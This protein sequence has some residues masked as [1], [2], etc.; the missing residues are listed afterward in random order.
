MVGASLGLVVLLALH[1][2]EAPVEVDQPLVRRNPVR[3][4]IG[5]FAELRSGQPGGGPD[6]HLTDLEVDPVAAVRLPFRTG[7]LT[8]AYEPRIFIAIHEYL[9][10]EAR[11]VAYLHRARLVLDTTPDPRWRVYL[12][13]RF[14]LGSNDFLPLSTVAT[15][16]PGTGAPPVQP[17]TTPTAPTPAPGQTTLPNTR[18]LDVIDLDSSVGFVYS[19]SPRWGWRTSAGYLYS[20]GRDVEVRSAL[21]LKKG[22]HGSTGLDWSA[23]RADTLSISLDGSYLRFS[24]GPQSTIAT[25]ST[26]WT[27]VWS[28]SVGTDLMA[29]VGGIH[30]KTPPEAGGQG[31]E[32]TNLYP[33]VGL[34]LRYTWA[35][36]FVTWQ[37]RLTV[38]AAPSA[39]QLTGA[40]NQRLSAGL[41]SS[42]S[43]VKQLVIAFTGAA[44]RSIDAPQRDIRLEGRATYVLG[45]QLGISL[46]ARAAWLEGSTLLGAQG[47]GWLAFLSVGTRVGTSV[48]GDSE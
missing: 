32:N 4:E 25:L 9:P 26:T 22:P 23:T 1:A 7:S 27:H 2:D 5:A 46:G 38:L 13:G 44:S 8:L 47:F 36:R 21:P 16:V 33:V 18:F 20:G 11:N 31:V 35:S 12:E 34:G 43:P 15:P 40:V 10:Q 45:P 17:G 3:F 30:A 14:A 28:R 48:F 29:G 19:L 41:E 24:S 39:D 6:T 42:L 37:N